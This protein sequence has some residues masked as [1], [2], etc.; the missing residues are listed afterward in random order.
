MK[1]DVVIGNPPYQENI[2]DRGE[3][4][5]IYNQFYDEVKKVSDVVTL[6]TPA[7]FLFDA[8]KTPSK[9][10]KMMLNDT[11]FKVID[12]FPDSKEVFSNVD[13][14][15]GVAISLWN[16]NKEFGAIETYIPN[17]IVKSILTKAKEKTSNNLSDI[18]YSNT[19]YKYDESFYNENPD[20]SN[21]VSGGS[22]RYLTSSVF[23]KFPEVFHREKPNTDIKYVPIIGRKDYERVTMYFP[24]KYLDV[25][26]NFNKYKV[27]LAS[28]NG[29][30]T[31]G[32][33]L[34]EPLIG[35]PSVGATETFVSFGNFE[36]KEEAEHL[37]K[38]TKCKFTR[39]LLGTKK[40]TQGN[41]SRKVWSNVVIQDFTR[42]SDISWDES[43]SNIDQQLYK[44]YN[45]DKD[46][47]EFIEK[48][49]E[50]ME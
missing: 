5:P 49:V 40:V 14:K 35:K 1:F 50:E 12:Y 47:I 48:N 33:R 23:S 11:H 42:D 25:P 19:S 2:E 9:W 46:E 24:E 17:P 16:K 39:L 8:G 4:P 34:S 38:Y 13:I 43:I 6:I 37:L 18:L 15:G 26:S 41:K 22:R 20:F 28:S 29:S 44:K 32:E 36:S 21:R 31:L 10:N 45:L 7:R 30:G 27:F 3:Q